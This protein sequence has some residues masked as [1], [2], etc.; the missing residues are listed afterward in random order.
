MACAESGVTC[1]GMMRGMKT[2]VLLAAA[3]LALA[4][5]SSSHAGK[6]TEAGARRKE[7]NVL[8]KEIFRK[9]LLV[10]ADISPSRPAKQRLTELLDGSYY[11]H[12]DPAI[13]YEELSPVTVTRSSLRDGGRILLVTLEPPS[14]ILP[15][16]LRTASAPD[17]GIPVIAEVDVDEAGGV[18]Q[19]LAKL[20]YLP[21]ETPDEETVARCLA[22]Y[23][24]MPERRSRMRCG[25]GRE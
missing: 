5:A 11:E 18:T 14:N 21:G 16:E 25:L 9:T 19:A 3:A 6:P 15:V 17:V 20:V 2:S 13:A 7:L 24:D 10:R 12:A 1:A 23:P 4:A 22:R 8:D